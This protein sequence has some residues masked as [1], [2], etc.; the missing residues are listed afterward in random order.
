MR[1]TKHWQFQQQCLLNPM[2]MWCCATLCFTQC[3]NWFINAWCQ[4]MVHKKIIYI[5]I[6]IYIYVKLCACAQSMEHIMFINERATSIHAFNKWWMYS[7]W[8]TFQAQ[9]ILIDPT[10]V[11]RIA[12][13]R[14]NKSKSVRVNLRIVSNTYDIHA[15]F[16]TTKMIDF[17]FNSLDVKIFA[18][19]VIH[20]L[21]H[22]EKKHIVHA[23]AHMAK[24]FTNICGV[25]IQN[26]QIR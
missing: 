21:L 19:D 5:Y 22:L 9:Y 10:C 8:C 23:L 24:W 26:S 6:Y 25:C 15:Y 3:S 18:N 4:H 12:M 13:L 16:T 7:R 1:G 11:A 17:I 2:L 14:A 20:K